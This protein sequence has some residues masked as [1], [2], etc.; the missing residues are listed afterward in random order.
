[1]KFLVGGILTLFI[2]LSVIELDKPGVTADQLLFVNASIGPLDGSYIYKMIR[3]FPIFLMA[4]IGAL[5]SYIYEPIFYFFG[6]SIYSI[7]LPVVFIMASSLLILYKAISLRVD[8]KI[9]LFTI[10]ILATDPSNIAYTRVDNGPTVLEF[11]FKCLSLLSLFLFLKTK[12]N[13]YLILLIIFL[14]LG[15]FNKTNFIWFINSLFLASLLFFRESIKRKW[16]LFLGASYLAFA[17]F[18]F[19]IFKIAASDYSAV[20][21]SFSFDKLLQNISVVTNNF[22]K[23]L[24]GEAFMQFVYGQ[25]PHNFTSIYS[26]ILVLI[27]ILGV[28]YFIKNRKKMSKGTI[29]FYFFIFV[30]FLSTLIQLFMTQLAVSAWHTYAVYPFITILTVIFLFQFPKKWTYSMLFFILLYNIFTY[31]L[32]IKNYSQPVS[33]L[34]WNNQFYKLLEFTDS[35]PESVLVTDIGMQTQF[36]LSKNYKKYTPIEWMIDG[37]RTY[38]SYSVLQTYFSMNKNAIAVVP[39]PDYPVFKDIQPN[40]YR[41]I[42]DY[43][44]HADVVATFTEGDKTIYTVYKITKPN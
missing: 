26:F 28:Y 41:F 32:Y 20:A 18:S 16:A 44:Y 34:S 1:M 10:L 4:Y 8:K 43:R 31:S 24:S 2:I 39:H 21:I 30:I 22:L 14:G 11:F 27:N 5:K 33:N 12:T 37:K 29:E 6:V 38:D 35:R 42:R 40:F 9:A 23:L 17:S 15:L 3:G 13:K 7:R 36:L 25:S 19:I